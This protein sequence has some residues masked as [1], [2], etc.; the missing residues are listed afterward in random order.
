MFR[1]ILS[2][3]NDLRAELWA[4]SAGIASQAGLWVDRAIDVATQMVVDGDDRA[5]VVEVAAL[6]HG[7]SRAD[8]IGPVTALLGATGVRTVPSTASEAE[9]FAVL[10][11]AFAYGGVPIEQFEGPWYAQLPAYDAQTEEQRKV[12]LLL[13]KR[14]HESEPSK[15]T[16]IADEIRHVLRG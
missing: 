10:R 13:D 15:R 12:M 9:R 5:E 16:A 11:Q 14:D 2:G 7:T 6:A 1:G 4:L 3:M 8:A